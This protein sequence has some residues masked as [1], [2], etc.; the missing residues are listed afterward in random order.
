MPKVLCDICG[1]ASGC[2]EAENV[3]K[4]RALE[5]FDSI[6]IDFCN[7]NRNFFQ[8]PSFLFKPLRSVDVLVRDTVK[9]EISLIEIKKASASAITT[10]LNEIKEKYI[11]SLFMLSHLK[12]GIHIKRCIIA[13]PD[14]YMHIHRCRNSIRAYF[15]ITQNIDNRYYFGVRGHLFSTMGLKAK[16]CY[17]GLLPKFKQCRDAV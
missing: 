10:Y 1:K 13:T 15:P 16:F 2:S 11:D 17:P 7:R 5:D 4:R 8:N 6:A 9:N 12:S 3:T 14:N